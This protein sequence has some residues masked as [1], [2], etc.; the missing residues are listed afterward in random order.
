MS[1]SYHISFGW[2]IAAV[3]YFIFLRRLITHIKTEYPEIYDSFG[4]KR[5]WYSAPDQIKFFGWLLKQKHNSL[6]DPK[7]S[8]LAII[9]QLLGFLSVIFLFT[10]PLSIQGAG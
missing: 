8:K 10:M 1:Y 4:G 3:F 2:I 9:T 5:V 6:Q 7:L